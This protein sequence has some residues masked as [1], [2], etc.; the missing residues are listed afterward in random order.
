[1]AT[2]FIDSEVAPVQYYQLQSHTP[3]PAEKTL[4]WLQGVTDAG[5]PAFDSTSEYA[6][7]TPGRTVQMLPGDAPPERHPLSPPPPPNQPTLVAP[8]PRKRRE[9]PPSDWI[10]PSYLQPKGTEVQSGKSDSKMGLDLEYAVFGDHGAGSEASYQRT[11][12]QAAGGYPPGEHEHSPEEIDVEPEGDLYDD[13]VDSNEQ[14]RPE[15]MMSPNNR[16]VPI[17]DPNNSRSPRYLSQSTGPSFGNINRPSSF[18]PMH[19]EKGPGNLNIQIQP[20][21]DRSHS[22]TGRESEITADPVGQISDEMENLWT[23]G[24]ALPP[25]KTQGTGTSAKWKPPPESAASE[26]SFFKNSGPPGSVH[27]SAAPVP[28]S[29]PITAQAT[30]NRV[31]PQSTGMTNRQSTARGSVPVQP[32]MTGMTGK[33]STRAP[34]APQTTGKQS[35]T[36]GGRHSMGG[37]RGP[38]QPQQT[39]M[40]SSRQSTARMQ[41]QVTG[42]K[43]SKVI[44]QMTGK[45]GRTS[46]SRAGQSVVQPSA[47]GPG[48]AVGGQSTA[49]GRAKSP[50]GQPS[51]MGGGGYQSFGDVMHDPMMNDGESYADE[52]EEG[53]YPGAYP[54]TDGNSFAG[55]GMAYMGE[56]IGRAPSIA[57][58]GHTLRGEKKLHPLAGSAVAPSEG[59]MHPLRSVPP[60]EAGGS[61]A[62]YRTGSPAGSRIS[63]R[64]SASGAGGPPADRSGTPTRSFHNHHSHGD[65]T[66][67]PSEAGFID[68]VP[69]MSE[70]ELLEVLKTP[71]TSYTVSPSVLAEEVSRTHY[72]DEDLCILLHAAED[73]NQHEVIRKAVRKAAKMRIKR[74]GIEEERKREPLSI[75]AAPD[76]SVAPPWARPLFDMLQ[77]AQTRLES[78]EGGRNRIEAPPSH[79]GSHRPGSDA[80]FDLNVGRT[81]VTAHGNIDASTIPSGTNVDESVL[82]GKTADYQHHPEDDYPDHSHERERSVVGPGTAMDRSVFGRESM[83]GQEQEQSIAGG[84]GDVE[85]E[86]YK[87]RVK[88]PPP[89]SEVSHNNGQIPDIPGEDQHDEPPPQ[90]A[91]SGPP[92]RDRALQTYQPP[93]V[94]QRVHQRL[95]NWA[96]VWP[97]SELD[98]ALASTERGHQVE[99]IALSVWCTQ[100]YKRYVRARLSEGGGDVS[101]VDRMYVPP[102]MADAIS[103]AVYNGRHGDACQMLKDLWTP[104]GLEGMP[105]LIIV[106]A[107]HRRD[108]HHWVTHR[109]SL[110]D[111]QLSTYDTY[112]EKS[113]PDGRPLGWWFAI[114]SA[115]P[116]AS[117][118]PAD[119][120]VQKMVRINR[121]LQ[122][123]VDCSVAAAAIWRNLLMGSK[124]ER[125]VDLERLRDLISTEVKSLK[126]RKE[127]GRLTVSNSRNED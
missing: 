40:T 99:E 4:L 62:P 50:L 98:K 101:K 107:R 76:S 32:Q 121:P 86:L 49:T 17:E 97:L 66:P 108:E 51:V 116:H 57:E 27:A 29:G 25:I 56:D 18:A 120:L 77:D 44:P 78:L 90:S 114:R 79:V 10:P 41:P 113:L 35:T 69:E 42:S 21:T 82:G 83:Y 5:P 112:P 63:H 38:I 94:W 87:L 13:D 16:T 36:A 111:G 48:S 72:H 122:L 92:D 30:G 119:A 1:M 3:P 65:S 93:P 12:Q 85:E 125:S 43:S 110:P 14:E 127:M 24:P 23:G 89:R 123:L 59:G 55:E 58:S 71:R 126:Q 54:G 115:W 118:P 75:A 45:S 73:P 103:T 15:S 28:S 61:A 20:P 7:E 11:L 74:L 68:R 102:N 96:M 60:S 70:R 100:V 46:M 81:P 91:V 34:I 37:S 105:R 8:S 47:R 26:A 31:V 124:A 109:F 9:D 106:L 117:Y 80:G 52:G 39:G 22:R 95:L 53:H 67:T 84:E 19:M 33:Q 104:F 64:R 88:Q 2:P 6:G